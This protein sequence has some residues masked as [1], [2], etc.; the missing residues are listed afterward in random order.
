MDRA[1]DFVK[2]AYG[3]GDKT[4]QGK[5]VVG[6]NGGAPGISSDLA[7]YWEDGWTVAVMCN[8]DRSAMQV[9]TRAEELILNLP[10]RTIVRD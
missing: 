8:Y 2:Y 3:F 9:S 10:P 4:L 1:P 6:H 7:M 5:H